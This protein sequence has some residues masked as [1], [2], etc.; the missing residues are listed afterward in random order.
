[1]LDPSNLNEQ[2]VA[3]KALAGK[4]L[5]N[6]EKSYHYINPKV[7]DPAWARGKE[8]IVTIGDHEFYNNVE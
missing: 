4:L 6:T 5:D 7:A 8:P 1:M 3:E 2:E